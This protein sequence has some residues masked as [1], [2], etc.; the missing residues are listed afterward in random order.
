MFNDESESFAIP[1]KNSINGN[2]SLACM[3]LPIKLSTLPLRQLTPK[4]FNNK[5]QT[6]RIKS[7]RK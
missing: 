2:N 5:E 4:I 3:A 1:F 7:K 6:S